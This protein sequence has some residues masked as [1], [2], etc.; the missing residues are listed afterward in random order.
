MK[1]RWIRAALVVLSAGLLCAAASQSRVKRAALEAMEKSFD[2]RVASIAEDPFILLGATRGLYLE[3]YG[4][5]F[6]ADCSLVSGP[7]IN[8]FKRT[9]SK[10]EVAE[11]REKKLHRLPILRDRMKEM[12]MS[13]AASLD[14]VPEQEQIV[15]SVALLYRSY[16]NTA[17]MPAQIMMQ[18]QKRQLLDAKLGRASAA[19]VIKVQEF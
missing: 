1:R 8:P 16:E 2:Q 12:L 3:G 10:E 6:T 9:I 19:E 11:V 15:V 14:E 17:G 13:A 7:T 18:G 4:V 5:V